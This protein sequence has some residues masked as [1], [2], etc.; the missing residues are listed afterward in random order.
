[1]RVLRL[2]QPLKYKRSGTA[3]PFYYVGANRSNPLCGRLCR[4]L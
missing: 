2:K 1:L 3:T 4:P